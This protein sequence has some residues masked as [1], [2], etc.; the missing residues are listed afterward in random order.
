MSP[1]THVL[2]TFVLSSVLLSLGAA[3]GGDSP[4][5]P[6]S[7]GGGTSS[8]VVLSEADRAEGKKVF[9]TICFT[10]HGLQGHGDGPGS[11]GLDPKPRDLG[12]KAWQQTVNDDHLRNVITMGGA[13][14]GKSPAMPAQPQLKGT[15]K[16]LEALIQHVRGLAH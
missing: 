14:V 8:A 3:C 16:V 5:T 9:E 2:A 15:P 7:G 10:C 11:A 13:A 12:D 1:R 6:K 4:S